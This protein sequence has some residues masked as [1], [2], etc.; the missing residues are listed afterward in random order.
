MRDFIVQNISGRRYAELA[1]LMSERFGE[2]FTA[3]QIH[4]FASNHH[5]TNGMPTGATPGERPKLFP[6]EIVTFI[7][8]N[9][10]GKTNAALQKLVNDAFGTTYSIVQIDGVKARNHI[11]SGLTGRFEK[12]HQSHNKGKKGVYAPGCER[13]WFKKG[14]IPHNHL[15]VGT[16]VM[17]TDGYLAVKIAE[18]NVWKMKHVIVWEEHNGKVPEGY[19]IIFA[20]RNHR[21]TAIENL[22][23]VTRG[24]LA[25]LNQR[26]LIKESP[27]LTES[28]ILIAK[29]IKKISEKKR[30]KP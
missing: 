4:A 15:E 26:G 11:S 8:E 25:I 14:G 22:R 18:P 29:I 12:G 30:R 1:D 17:T 9:A 13:G 19:V 28:G 16:E 3:A 21:N 6:D 27:E 10:A 5:L 24:E 23:L 7:R 2:V 20:D